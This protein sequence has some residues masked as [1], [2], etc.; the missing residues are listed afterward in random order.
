MGGGVIVG[1][2]VAVYLAT[3][4][5]RFQ[6]ALVAALKNCPLTGAG[7]TRHTIDNLRACIRA[8]GIRGVGGTGG[9][10]RH[11]L[12]A[13]RFIAGSGTTSSE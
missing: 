7:R 13:T 5:D 8:E 6:D 1:S 12:G 3:S 4:A 9:D 10:V 11:V 2:A